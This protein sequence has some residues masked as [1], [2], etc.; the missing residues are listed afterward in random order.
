MTSDLLARA[1]AAATAETSPEDALRALLTPLHGEL[2]QRTGAFDLPDGVSQFFVAGAFLV[3]PDQE[4]HMLTASLGFPAEQNRLMIPIDGGHPARVRASGA[5]LHLPDTEAE[6]GNFKQYLKTARMGSAIYAPMI[7]QGRFLGQIVL[8]G[9][10]RGSL[11]AEDFGV[12]CA[13]APLAAAVYV[14]QG[15]PEWLTRI[16]PPEDG[17]R[18]DP[19]GM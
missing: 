12:M 4:W 8:A 1:G 2:G 16:Y 5:P 3:A 6:A 9:R 18:V 19:Q 15:G 7:W 13:A 11:S 14:A 10:A 17:F